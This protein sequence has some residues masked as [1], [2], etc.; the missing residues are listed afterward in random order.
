MTFILAVSPSCTLVV[1]SEAVLYVAR[2][3]YGTGEE[4][5]KPKKPHL[6]NRLGSLNDDP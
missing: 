3:K 5:I 4:Q 2:F 1:K 6:T